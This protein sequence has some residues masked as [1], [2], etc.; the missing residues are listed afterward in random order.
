[1]PST[2]STLTVKTHDGGQMPAFVALPASGAGPGLVLLQEIFGVTEYI[3][4]R[5]R[6]LA[7][8]G[9][10]VVA[11]ELYWRLGPNLSTDERTEAGVQEAFGY[12]GKL[13]VAHAVDDAIATLEPVRAM[14]ETEARA[15]ALGYC[16]GAR[17]AAEG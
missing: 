9:Y 10:V 1:M 6:D 8:Q 4:S 12:F 13:D 3:K 16:R 2:D 11:P 5:A 17:P 7:E 14:P 15:G